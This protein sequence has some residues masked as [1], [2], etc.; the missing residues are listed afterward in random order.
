[1]SEYDHI[2][3]ILHLAIDIAMDVEDLE[4]CHALATASEMTNRRLRDRHRGGAENTVTT[5]RVCETT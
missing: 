1:M 3:A 5:D 4:L 2:E